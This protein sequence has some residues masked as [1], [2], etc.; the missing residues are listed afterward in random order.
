METKYTKGPTK[1][2]EEY[3]KSDKINPA[4]YGI[5]CNGIKICE[6]D[7]SRNSNAKADAKLFAAASIMLDALI[8]AKKFLN[9]VHISHDNNSK[10][11]MAYIDKAIKKATE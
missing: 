2:V 7:T 3:V 10:L 8:Q 4:W 5:W 11:C 6:L 1:I 9:E